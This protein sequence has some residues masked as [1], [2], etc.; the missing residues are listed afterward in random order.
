MAKIV[1]NELAVKQNLQAGSG[2]SPK[3]LLLRDA[4]SVHSGMR[5]IRFL[6]V[7]FGACAER[8]SNLSR[9][10]LGCSLAIF[11]HP[12]S[13]GRAGISHLTSNVVAPIRGRGMCTSRPYSCARPSL[14][15]SALRSNL[16]ILCCN[17]PSM[18]N[19]CVCPLL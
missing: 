5:C 16:S 2:Q 10:L 19:T 7:V 15:L 4:F 6:F 3:V 12:F 9:G 8:I 14:C 13:L 11:V 17:A 18:L 1:A